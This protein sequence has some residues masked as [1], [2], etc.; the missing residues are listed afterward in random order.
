MTVIIDGSLEQDLPGGLKTRAS[1]KRGSAGFRVETIRLASIPEGAVAPQVKPA[2]R[3]DV[4]KYQPAA[5]VAVRISAPAHYRR[6]FHDRWGSAQTVVTEIANWQEGPVGPLLG[7][8]WHW[9]TT[10]N[11]HH[12]VGHLRLPPNIADQLISKSGRNGILVTRAG[13]AGAAQPNA[14]L[15]LKKE[16]NED[17]ECYYRRAL[18]TATSRNQS[19]KIR[20]G[21]GSDLGVLRLETDCIP[22]G[23]IV[24]EAQTPRTWEQEDVA[25]FFSDQGWQELR[26]FHRQK[27]NRNCAVWSL[28]G[29]PP[30]EE[31]L[32]PWHYVDQNKPDLQVFATAQGPSKKLR[33][34]QKDKA[35]IGSNAGGKDGEAEDREVPGDE[36]MRPQPFEDDPQADRDRSPRRTKAQGTTPEQE[37][38]AEDEITQ[39]MR[40]GWSRVDQKG[41]GDCAF[42]CIAAARHFRSTGETLTEESSRREGG[43]LR[44]VAVAH[45]RSHE[46]R[47]FPYFAKDPTV[48][49]EELVPTQQENAEAFQDWLRQMATPHCWA[50]GLSL[51]GVASKLGTVLVVW[52]RSTEQTWMR[53]CLAQSFSKDQG[54]GSFAKIAKGQQP[55]VLLL[56]NE[57]YTWLRPSAK[58]AEV[59]RHWLRESVIPARRALAGGGGQEDCASNA[60]SAGDSVPSTPSVHSLSVDTDCEGD[61]DLPVEDGVSRDAC[62]ALVPPVL[63]EPHG[64]VCEGPTPSVHSLSLHT[65]SAYTL[66]ASGAKPTDLESLDREGNWQN[67]EEQNARALQALLQ[68]AADAPARRRLKYKQPGFLSLGQLFGRGR[69]CS[70]TCNSQ[71]A[72]GPSHQS[73]QGSTATLEDLDVSE[74]QDAPGALAEGPAPWPCPECGLVLQAATSSSLSALKKW[75][76][77]SRHP[78][79]D[80]ERVVKR[81]KGDCFTPTHSIP[82]D[83]AS[84]ECPICCKRLPTLSSQDYKRSVRAH[85]KAEHPGE[86]PRALYHKRSKGRKRS[87]DSCSKLQLAIHQAS[88]EVRHA[89]HDFF[90]FKPLDSRDKNWRGQVVYCKRCLSRLQQQDKTVAK[91]SCSE[92]RARLENNLVS[93][94]R[95]RAWWK[96]MLNHEPLNAQEFLRLSGWTKEGLAE[97]LGMNQLSWSAR[98]WEANRHKLLKEHPK[99]KR[100]PKG[101]TSTKKKAQKQKTPRSAKANATSSKS[102]GVRAGSSS[103]RSS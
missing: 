35:P 9:I 66:P 21:G 88:R 48:P 71:C 44:G 87:T 4:A 26:V 103:R 46:D 62:E 102:K 41:T 55:I 69:G 47:Y 19:L 11:M 99:P 30:S 56:E 51:Q 33:T 89:D 70:S 37:P 97:L 24:V 83:Q 52:I 40:E 73:L 78:D 76:C 2:V 61:R 6:I 57:H 72:K 84:W 22:E 92:R 12:L 3:I 36:A 32:G 58:E 43:L 101:Q 94:M 75:R 42:R 80:I 59:P 50:D 77:R 27:R 23:P 90:S 79:F 16:E 91:L 100:G 7:G 45:I 8:Q 49:T 65:A 15:W 38:L 86:T 53:V 67:K 63:P 31:K 96:A 5:K 98:N 39:A 54:S 25:T 18:A 95:K 20:A 68:G 1:V 34:A 82:K 74:H 60:P 64:Q 13:V 28:R 29:L 81:P 93:R 14:M 85:I 17:S 10:K